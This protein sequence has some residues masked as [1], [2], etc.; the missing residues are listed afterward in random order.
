MQLTKEKLLELVQEVLYPLERE[1]G[2]MK[3]THKDYK[4]ALEHVGERVWVHTER[5]QRNRKFNGMIGV[6]RA[7][8]SNNR[9][10]SPWFKTNA[11]ALKNCAFQVS[12]G[13]AIEK[14]QGG[15]DRTLVAGAV[16]DIANISEEY[17]NPALDVTKQPFIEITFNPK[18]GNYFYA[19]DEPDKPLS[20]CALLYFTASED[21]KWIMSAMGLKYATNEK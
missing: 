4:D 2:K 18:V 17:Y 9:V 13:K 12:G 16:G 21:G 5:T 1:G 3:G 20:G 6:Y 14:I 15:G 11:I 10:G 19:V 8:K 7:G